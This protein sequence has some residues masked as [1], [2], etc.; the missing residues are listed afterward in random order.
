MRSLSVAFLCFALALTGC[1][2][3]RPPHTIGLALDVGGRGDQSFNDGALRGLEAMSAGL[4]YT[5]RGYEPLPDADYN[6]LLPADLR[7]KGLPHLGIPEP[8]VLS[9]KAQEDYEPNLQLLVDQ[10]VELV[11]AVG[12]MME[13][14]VRAVASRDLSLVQQKVKP[15]PTMFLLLASPVLGNDKKPTTLSNVRAVVFREHEGSF[16]AGALAGL[17][18]QTG[19]LGFV[20]G[21]QLPLIKKFEA[22]FR[23]GIR[24]VNPAIAKDVLVA[25]T[26]TFDDEKKGI[27]VGS[28]LYGRGCDIVFHAAGLD[29]LGVI[30]AAEKAGKL[31]IGVDSD[32]AHVAPKNVLTSMIKRVDLAVYGAVRDVTTGKFTTG[33]VVLGLAQDAVGLAPVGEQLVVAIPPEKRAAALAKVAALKLAIVN[34]KIVV[35]SNLEELEKFVPPAEAP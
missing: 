31:V 21:M 27:E 22:G 14:A 35:P 29:G 25:Y 34:G 7:V 16:L 20:G 4:K 19:K 12:F 24:T 9:G 30:K 5:A 1:K 6:A 8:L 11:V 33:D 3:S 2:K 28:D 18:T 17:L 13:P 23:A 26:G 32:Q 15:A 10:G